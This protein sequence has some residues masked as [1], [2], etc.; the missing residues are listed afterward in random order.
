MELLISSPPQVEDLEKS[1]TEWM[2]YC[3]ILEV[4]IELLRVRRE[5]RGAEVIET[6][7]AEKIPSAG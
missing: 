1:R 6:T 7:P 4:G 3:Q 5:R 2:R